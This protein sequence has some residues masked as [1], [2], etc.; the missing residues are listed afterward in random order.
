MTIS[1]AEVMSVDDCERRGGK[2]Y[3]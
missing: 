2:K 3:G 1:A